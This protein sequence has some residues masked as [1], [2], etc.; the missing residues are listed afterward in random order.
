MV[1]H[2]AASAYEQRDS[3]QRRSHRPRHPPSHNRTL[4]SASEAASGLLTSYQGTDALASL[5]GSPYQATHATD[6]HPRGWVRRA[7][8]SP[9]CAASFFPYS[10]FAEEER[11]WPPEGASPLA[12]KKLRRSGYHPSKKAIKSPPQC[13]SNSEAASGLLTRLQGT[14]ALANL[15]GS[16]YQANRT[17]DTHPRGW[18]RRAGNTP[19]CAASF[20]PY[21][22]FAGEERIWPPEGAS[23]IAWKSLRRSGFQ[24]RKKQSSH[25]RSA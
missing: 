2:T 24:P 7:G 8:S 3:V 11:I 6:T 16:P 20:F 14:D 22:F 23:P 10:F 9:P 18:V 12:W 25:N 15:P 13:V 5:S 17:T 21:S 4:V 1:P 19:P